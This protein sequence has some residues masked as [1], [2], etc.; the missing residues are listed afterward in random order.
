MVQKLRKL[1]M[2]LAAILA[3]SAPALVPVTVAAQETQVTTGLCA[4]V[5]LSTNDTD[6]TTDDVA[7]REKIDDVIGTIINVLS[8]VVGV[9]SVIMIIIGGLKYIT[10]GGDSS[11]VSSAK[12]TILYAIVGL[13]VVALSQFIVQFVLGTVVE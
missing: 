7:A 1:G 9:V 11:S 4:G 12:N 5:N 3:L 6:C 10:S 13:I 8:L 2:S